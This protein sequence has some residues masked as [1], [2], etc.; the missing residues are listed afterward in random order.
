MICTRERET[1]L[2]SVLKFKIRIGVT[3]PGTV[4]SQ[5]GSGEGTRNPDQTPLNLNLK[6]SDY[7]N[8]S[9]VGL[10]KMGPEK[11]F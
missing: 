2:R 1:G 3:V 7:V 6:T 4:H 5:I 10:E 11:Y 8:L 9:A